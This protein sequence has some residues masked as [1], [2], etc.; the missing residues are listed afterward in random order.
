[1]VEYIHRTLSV[2][3]TL[4]LLVSTVVVARMK[5]RQT[6]AALAL[7][8]SLGLLIV[9]ILLGAVVVTSN[10]DAVITAL[11]LANATA[12]FGIMVTA[13]VLMYLREKATA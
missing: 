1:L 13:G 11:H 8:L 10:L 2:L 3:T 4:F 6:G 5:P 12:L 9:Q 7:L